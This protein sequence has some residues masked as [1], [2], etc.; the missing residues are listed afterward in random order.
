[1]GNLEDEPPMNAMEMPSE[2]DEDSGA[3]LVR[4][5]EAC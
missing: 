5:Q 4:L 3:N 1:V 2:N